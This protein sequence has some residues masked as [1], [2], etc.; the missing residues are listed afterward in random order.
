M[1]KAIALLLLLL[2]FGAFAGGIWWSINH[3]VIHKWVLY[4]R[5]SQELSFLGEEFGQSDYGKLSK[6]LPECRI[7]WNVPF[8]GGTVPSDTR[9]LSLESLSQED[10][11]QLQFFPELERVYAEGCVDY[12][13][14]RALIEARP[15]C[16]VTY[17]V[18]IDGAD[19]A[20][21]ADTVTVKHLTQEDLER[22][23]WLPSLNTV[24][25]D[26]CHDYAQLR[27]LRLEHPD[28]KVSYWVNLG[29]SRLPHN[30]KSADVENATEQELLEGL[31]ALLELTK[32]HLVNTEAGPDVLEG[33]RNTYPNLNLSCE[34]ELCGKRYDVDCKE[35]YLEGV[36]L[37]SLEKVRTVAACLP[38]LERL[39]LVDCT[40]GGQA[41][42][43]EDL[44][45]LRDEVRDQYKL[46]WKVYC[47]KVPAMTDD[48]WFMPI[49]KG[50]YYFQH[51]HSY[52]LRYC[53]DMICI[54]LGHSRIVNVDFAAFMPHLKYLIITESAVQDISGISN[55][56][57]LTY[58]ENKFTIIRDLSPLL[59]CT[60]LE[61]VNL[62][63]PEYYADMTPICQMTWLKNLFVSKLNN[64]VLL[65]L[66][67]ALPDTR[68]DYHDRGAQTGMGWRNLPSYYEM[69]DILGMEYM[70]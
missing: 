22:M 31:P 1:K 32:L 36:E 11:A 20:Q 61:D 34:V 29:N 51:D 7:L 23:Q 21:D 10:I 33:L 26:E 5:D 8:Q 15:E 67:E 2:L 3:Y 41:I 6:K 13:E 46:V 42:E 19:Y 16:T 64:Q 28:W 63:A 55:C 58:F 65:E 14:L 18:R 9:E 47:G 70:M 60:A 30:T 25:A 44:A 52:N 43:N 45:K 38:E 39:V 56:K 4:P 54:D 53:E 57:E 50:E 59:G 27:Q 35:V 37:G 49:Q 68:V 69:R 48:T 62:C 12:P 24:K 66:Q 17:L 40:I